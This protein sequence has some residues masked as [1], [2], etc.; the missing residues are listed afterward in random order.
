M[1]PAAI[2][3]IK[4]D[5]VDCFRLLMIDIQ[6]FYESIIRYLR[7]RNRCGPLRRHG[8]EAGPGAVADLGPGVLQRA[9]EVLLGRVDLIGLVQL[10][11]E[12]RR[13]L[14]EPRRAGV[15]CDEVAEG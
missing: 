8:R 14:T 12:V 15:A 11:A 1:F 10:P 7:S 9:L 3:S 4:L 13:R 6:I 5:Y 2:N